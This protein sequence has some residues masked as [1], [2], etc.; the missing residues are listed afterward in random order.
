MDFLVFAADCKDSISL[1]F[2]NRFL[3]FGLIVAGE[4]LAGLNTIALCAEEGFW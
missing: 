4:V 2:L 1:R 3:A